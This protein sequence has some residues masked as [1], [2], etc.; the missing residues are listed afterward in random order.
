MKPDYV[1][2][3]GMALGLRSCLPDFRSPSE[4]ANGFVW[5]KSGHV[6]APDWKADPNCGHG[7]H[8][9]AHGEGDG[10]LLCYDKGAHWLV[11]EYDPTKAIDLDGKIKVPECTVVFC[12]DESTAPVWIK[13]HDP[14][15]KLVVGSTNTGGVGSTNTGGVR[16][17]NTGGDDSTV[18]SG[19]MGLIIIYWWD[20]T[21]RRVAVG[22]VGEDGIEPNTFYRCD[23]RGKLVKT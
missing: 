12:G 20:G 3:P 2:P 16:S 18:K 23:E 14:S 10:G 1:L 13:S 21:R 19:E 8:L 9:L 15:A 7:L 11:C 22:Y 4:D 5:P 6:S 17:T